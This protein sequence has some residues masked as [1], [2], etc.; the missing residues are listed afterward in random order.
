MTLKF[1]KPYLSVS[2]ITGQL[3]CETKLELRYQHGDVDTA[4][5]Q[6]GR[7]RHLE[8]QLESIEKAAQKIGQTIVEPAKQLVS[9]ETKNRTELWY[10]R[11]VYG[12]AILSMLPV[13]GELRELPIF[14]KISDVWVV[15]II[16]ELY[17]KGDSLLLLDTKTRSKP[18]VPNKDQRKSSRLQLMLYRSMIE[19]HRRVKADLDEVF[20]LLRLDP[21]ELRDEF[22]EALLNAGIPPVSLRSVFRNYLTKLQELPPSLPSM[23]LAYEYQADGRFLGKDDF[24]YDGLWLSQALDQ[25]LPFWKEERAAKLLNANETFKCGY[26]EQKSRCKIYSYLYPAKA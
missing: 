12:S 2:D 8:I 14:A 5:K 3:W 16:D 13:V 21:K 18:T 9:I 26:C 4:A 10:V 23:T 22:L 6:K 25:L 19:W 15:G 20:T 17:L 1:D 24:V 11:A 7:E